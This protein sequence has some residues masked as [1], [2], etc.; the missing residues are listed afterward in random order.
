MQ[1]FSDGT[2]TFHMSEREKLAFKRGEFITSLFIELSQAFDGSYK[3]LCF[4]CFQKKQ[5]CFL[6]YLVTAL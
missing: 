2:S 6:S 1:T 4:S 3:N 5:N